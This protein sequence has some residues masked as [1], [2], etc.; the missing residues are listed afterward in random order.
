MNTTNRG[1]L[2]GIYYSLE[3]INEV[4]YAIVQK[5]EEKE[6]GMNGGAP[7]EYT[8]GNSSFDLEQASLEIKSAM[9]YIEEY[10]PPSVDF[11]DYL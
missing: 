1:V 6:Q 4:L 5:E 11:E 10:L 8:R 9:K 7:L 2:Q 3:R